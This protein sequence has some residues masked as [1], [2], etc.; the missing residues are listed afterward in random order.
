MDQINILEDI[1]GYINDLIP[2]NVCRL[3]YHVYERLI[4]HTKEPSA[5]IM[6]YQTH[7]KLES[8]SRSNDVIINKPKGKL[9]KKYWSI[10]KGLMIQFF[11]YDQISI[12]SHHEHHFYVDLT[13]YSG[14]RIGK[15][16]YFQDLKNF[17]KIQH[18]KCSFKTCDHDD[19]IC[20]SLTWKQVKKFK[21][22]IDLQT[23]SVLDSQEI[24]KVDYSLFR[25]HQKH[26]LEF[27]I[28]PSYQHLPSIEIQLDHEKKLLLRKIRKGCCTDVEIK[29]PFI[30]NLTLVKSYEECYV[31]DEY[32][33]LVVF[34]DF[35]ILIDTESLSAI[36]IPKHNYVIKC[37][38]SKRL[39][40]IQ[41]QC[42]KNETSHYSAKFVKFIDKTP[43]ITFD[44]SEDE[45]NHP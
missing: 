7:L 12:K 9:L 16:V 29:S 35:N 23:M 26:T 38:S 36:R 8:L 43:S 28:H 17:F 25:N 42:P 5:E 37:P 14:F 45:K 40:E 2:R 6:W 22:F 18:I 20:I 15:K 3:W 39:I 30:G 19:I 1:F 41:L 33:Y 27:N 10:S 4:Q 11:C 21:C 31:L 32:T 34:S 24:Q 13:D 44:Q